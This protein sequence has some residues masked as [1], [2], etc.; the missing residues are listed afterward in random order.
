MFACFLTVLTAVRSFTFA[1]SKVSLPR[2]QR[3]LMRRVVQKS[4]SLSAAGLWSPYRPAGC[5]LSAG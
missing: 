4:A 1:M 3:D 5:L 2:T